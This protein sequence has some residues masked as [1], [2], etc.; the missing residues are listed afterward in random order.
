MKKAC[1]SILVFALVLSL[2]TPAFAASEQISG[3]VIDTATYVD[4][5]TGDS[6]E[7]EVLSSTSSLFK[8]SSLSQNATLIRISKNGCLDELMHIDFET[9]TLQHEYPDGTVWTQ[10]LSDVVTI[11][12]AVSSEGSENEGQGFD[13]STLVNE[14]ALN[15]TDYVDNEPFNLDEYGYPVPLNAPLYDGYSAMGSRGGFP[16]A[17]NMRGYMQRR[18]VGIVGNYKAPLFKFSA[19]TTIGTAAGIIYTFLSSNGIAGIV[20]GTIIS[21]LGVI[22]DVVT[23][24]WSVQFDINTCEWAYRIRLNSDMGL[25]IYTF[26]RTKD[27][28]RMYAPN[29]GKVTYEYRGTSFDG[30][31]LAQNSE[32]IR[33]AI[34]AYQERAK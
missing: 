15:Q 19:G 2:L 18:T 34:D 1:C 27:Y 10:A 7:M 17:P 21:M 22:I 33:Y 13:V 9:N 25:I 5:I 20:L 29:N 6:I 32:L 30:G 3:Q 11:T 4:R 14:Y 8:R 16:S 12:E 26:S 31:P 28:M 23:F 24:D